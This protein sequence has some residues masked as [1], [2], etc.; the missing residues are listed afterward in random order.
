MANDIG[1]NGTEQ[2]KMSRFFVNIGKDVSST[3]STRAQ[4]STEARMKCN[5][6]LLSQ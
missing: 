4:I 5:Y 3:T 2:Q 6:Y 1:I